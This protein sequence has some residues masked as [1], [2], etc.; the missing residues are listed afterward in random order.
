M[1]GRFQ[2]RIIEPVCPTLIK[3]V[4]DPMPGLYLGEEAERRVAEFVYPL[5]QVR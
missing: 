1:L 4:F 3:H 2:L 5:L